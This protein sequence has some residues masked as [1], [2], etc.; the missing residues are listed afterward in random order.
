MSFVFKHPGFWEEREWRAIFQP[1]TTKSDF[2]RVGPERFRLRDG[3]RIAYHEC[4]LLG[5]ET[6]GEVVIGP[7]SRLT[8]GD[9]KRIVL[10]QNFRVSNIRRS[11]IPY[12]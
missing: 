1:P 11:T 8:E 10:S 3:Q 2:T 9:A 6:I 5:E 7:K 4:R 12:R